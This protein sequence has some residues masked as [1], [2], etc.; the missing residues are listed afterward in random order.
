MLKRLDSP[1]FGGRPVGPWFKWK[2]APLTADCV[3]VPDVAFDAVQRS[4]RHKAGLA[5]RFPRIRRIRWDKPA[6]E[7]DRVE[8]LTA[9]L[10]QGE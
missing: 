9:M 8:S 7:A 3:L 1:Y 10:A 2:R 6:A 5:L 4:T